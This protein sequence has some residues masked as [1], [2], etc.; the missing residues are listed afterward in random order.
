M[1]AYK[2]QCALCNL[3]HRELLDAAHIIPDNEPEGSP[4]VKNGLSLCKIHHSAYDKYFLGIRPDY[5][6]DI[7]RDLLNEIDGP[8]LQHGL[9]ELHNKRIWLPRN[10]INK[11]DPQRLANRYELFQAQ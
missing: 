2:D 10:D 9:K 5:T 6:I 8:M 3:R 4:I 1:A 7:R 11:P